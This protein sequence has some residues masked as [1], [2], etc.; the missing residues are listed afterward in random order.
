MFHQDKAPND[1]FSKRIFLQD[2]TPVQQTQ[3]DLT[4]NAETRSHV[5]GSNQGLLDMVLE[6]EP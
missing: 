1:L 5:K 3:P 6:S 2:S 4:L